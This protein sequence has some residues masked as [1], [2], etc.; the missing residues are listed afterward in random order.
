[1]ITVLLEAKVLGE[2]V[3]GVGGRR[4]LDELGGAPREVRELPDEL[5]D[6]V[7]REL[8]VVAQ[9][10]V[11]WRARGALEPVVAR[12]EEVER[13][14]P[15]DHVLVLHGAG[16]DVGTPGRGEGLA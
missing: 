4:L 7:R 10:V 6:L 2:E 13:L 9:H 12:Q 16:G 14:L 3:C 11:V 8:R 15:A 1:M 5:L